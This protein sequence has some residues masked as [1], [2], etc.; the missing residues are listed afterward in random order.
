M[1]TSHRG[2]ACRRSDLPLCAGM[3]AVS[4]TEGVRALPSV[5][6]SLAQSPPRVFSCVRVHWGCRR[7]TVGG[8]FKNAASAYNSFVGGGG[9][10]TSDSLGGNMASGSW[11]AVLGGSF[12][13]AKG[14]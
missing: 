9:A 2:E 1:S 12:N 14:V 4:R 5:R 6:R 11:S 10:R 8:G 3:N 13:T 7:S